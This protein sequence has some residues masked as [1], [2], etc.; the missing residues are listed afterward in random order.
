[1]ME[2]GRFKKLSL[3]KRLSGGELPKISIIDI[4]GETTT[5][6][7]QLQEKIIATHAQGKQSI[8][9]LNRRGF[10]H[11]FHCKSCG[12]QMKCKN[13][14]VALTYY[15]KENMMKCHYC[16]Y[17]H[18]PITICP[19]CGSL[20]VGYSGFGTEMVEEEV[21]KLFPHM[22]VARIDSD[23][24]A[25]RGVLGKILSDFKEGKIDLLLGTQ[26]VAKGLNF[27]KVALVGIVLADTTL[28]LPDFRSTERCYSLITQVAGRAGRY[29]LGGEVYIQTYFPN[30]LAILLA[31]K[32]EADSFY[33]Q[34]LET[35]KLLGF[36]PFSRLG[37]LLFRGK[38]KER[39]I[40]LA[41]DVANHL[42]RI[43]GGEVEVLG[44]AESPIAII[45][46]NYR[47]HILLRAKTAK[48][49]Q[50]AVANSLHLFRKDQLVYVEIDI[51]P[52]SLL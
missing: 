16:G 45:N 40:S 29:A 19:E 36:P 14:S 10:N 37:K 50:I 17:Q 43:C 33:K 23:S 26:M 1:M 32:G 35:R 7:K 4:S 6:S 12:F 41:S 42:N 8:L 3:T 47:Y 44:P 9:F 22:R 27:P 34:E 52:V 31:A 25:K 21:A 38:N 48:A 13:C 46:K 20:D 2:S 28:Y 15:K 24:V 30:A 5:I 51:D 18:R 39:V 49:I 11:F